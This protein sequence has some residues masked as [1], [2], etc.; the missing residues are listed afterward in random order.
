MTVS[1]IAIV[2][3][4]HSSSASP[5][6]AHSCLSSGRRPVA[7]STGFGRGCRGKASAC[8]GLPT[9][10]FNELRSS[11]PEG[12]R[13]ATYRLTDGVTFVHIATLETPEKNPLVAL[14]SFKTFQKELKDRCVDPPV[15]TELSA[16]DSYASSAFAQELKRGAEG[17]AL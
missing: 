13:Y 9:Q 12:I 2:K 10:V 15:V 5:S 17:Q 11:C 1:I 14:P 4:P 6:T 16:V 7:G 8:F 3:K